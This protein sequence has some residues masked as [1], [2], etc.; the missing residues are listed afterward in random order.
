MKT[1]FTVVVVQVGD[2]VLLGYKKTNIGKGFWNGFGGRVEPNETE[3]EG[4]LRELREETGLEGQQ[5]ERSGVIAVDWR[6]TS[7]LFEL[8]F[9]R[10][11]QVSGTAGETREMRPRW[12]PVN[13]IPYEHMWEADRVWMPLLLAGKK[14]SGTMRYDNLQSRKLLAHDIREAVYA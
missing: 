7:D 14:F 13:K 1:V 11:T 3:E 6:D 8:H 4:A 12:T 9:Y 10:V 2:Q 5:I